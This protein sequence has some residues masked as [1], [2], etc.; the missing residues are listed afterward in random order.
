[1]DVLVPLIVR[2]VSEQFYKVAAEA[3][4]VIT[5]LIRV[6]RPRASE[7]GNFD[8]SPYVDSIYEAIIGKLKATDIDQVWESYLCIKTL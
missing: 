6:L 5:S 3:L 4:T 7:K 2:A 8:Y 1:M